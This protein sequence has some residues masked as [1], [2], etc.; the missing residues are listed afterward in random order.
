MLGVVRILAHL[1]NKPTDN[2]MNRL[3]LQFAA[4][5]WSSLTNGVVWRILDTVRLA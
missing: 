2:M 5:I 4:K 1:V 3:D